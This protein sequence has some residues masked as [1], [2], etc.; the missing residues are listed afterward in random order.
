MIQIQPASSR[1]G[2][3]ARGADLPSRAAGQGHA[4]ARRGAVAAWPR[5]DLEP[6]LRGARKFL[7]HSG[8]A[9]WHDQAGRAA[10]LR[11]EHEA[12][13]GGEIVRFEAP[14]FGRHG[15]H[16]PAFQCFFHRPE[17]VLPVRGLDH[18]E[19]RGIDPMRGKARRIGRARLGFGMIL[20]DPD[21]RRVCMEGGGETRGQ[22]QGKA[23]R[24]RG[25]AGARRHDFM[26]G[27]PCNDAS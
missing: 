10:F 7:R 16:G 14:D 5:P 24:C 21:D 19:A 8:E 9:R 13:R 3:D 4:L 23:R 15:R 22:G 11:R 6:R 27:A 25:I 1:T 17:A 20:D 2:P 26:Q 12:A 18:D